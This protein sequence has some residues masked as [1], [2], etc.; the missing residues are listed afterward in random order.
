[1][2]KARKFLQKTQL[3]QKQEHVSYRGKNNG[4][5]II[6]LKQI[7]PEIRSEVQ[8]SL[9]REVEK[10]SKEQNSVRVFTN[11]WFSTG[12]FLFLTIY[13]GPLNVQNHLHCQ[14]YLT[15]CVYTAASLACWISGRVTSPWNLLQKLQVFEEIHQFEQKRFFMWHRD[16]WRNCK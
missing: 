13:F 8:G 5:E 9:G 14:T 4:T 6:L 16:G 12:W 1:M 7:R 3:Q 15:R 10:H 2:V 11:P